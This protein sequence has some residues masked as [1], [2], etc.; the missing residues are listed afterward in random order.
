M[1]HVSPRK[2]WGRLPYDGQGVFPPA[3]SALGALRRRAASNFWKRTPWWSR[4]LLIPMARL[5]WVAACARHVW[6]YARSEGLPPRLAPRLFVDCVRSGARP[7]EA[8]IWRQFFQPPG[9]HPLPGRA[10]A[11]LLLQLGSASE[12]RLLADKQATAELLAKAGL[13]TPRLLKV[14]PRGTRHRPLRPPL[15]PA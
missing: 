7:N 13:P 10:A 9:P 6:D 1:W 3:Y 12:H 15:V 8:L 11:V 2:L 5:G 14:V 4:P